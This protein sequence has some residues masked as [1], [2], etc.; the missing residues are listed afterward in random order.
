MSSYVALRCL[1]VS[2][3]QH[4]HQTNHRRQ[5]RR[6]NHSRTSTYVCRSLLLALPSCV[7]KL[8]RR[9]SWSLLLSY[10]TLGL[11]IP[12]RFALSGK[13]NIR[14]RHILLLRACHLPLT[15]LR[16]LRILDR[17]PNTDASLSGN[18]PRHHGGFRP[19]SQ[20]P[21]S[22]FQA[23]PPHDAVK[24]ILVLA[25]ISDW[26]YLA[27][28]SDIYKNT[29]RQTVTIVHPLATHSSYSVTILARRDE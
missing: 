20:A 18:S 24:Q 17:E 28:Y 6:R 13:V 4:L 2:V 15:S 29:S 21:P 22:P 25:L 11:P 1:F 12:E 7:L 27:Y 19:L 16:H 23:S 5:H 26:N 3:Y 8:L 10:L 14:V 9:L